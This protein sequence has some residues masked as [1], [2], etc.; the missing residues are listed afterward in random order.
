MEFEEAFKEIFL[1]DDE[2]RI[3]ES[4]PYPSESM[5][6]EYETNSDKE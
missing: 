3:A 1:S 4:D 6:S 2:K 5:F